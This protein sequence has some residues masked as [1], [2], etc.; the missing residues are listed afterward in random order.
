[1]AIRKFFIKI[2]LIFLND[3]PIANLVTFIILNELCNVFD[4][5]NSLLQIKYF[6][7]KILSRKAAFFLFMFY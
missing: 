5:N 1:M 3:F 4:I 6:F 2:C 7:L